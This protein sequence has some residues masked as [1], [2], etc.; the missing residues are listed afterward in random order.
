MTDTNEEIKKKNTETEI[1]EEEL[2]KVQGGTISTLEVRQRVLENAM[3][4]SSTKK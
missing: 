2:E 4:I 3:R 1:Q